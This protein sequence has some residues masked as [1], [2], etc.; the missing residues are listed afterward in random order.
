MWTWERSRR[1]KSILGR[2]CILGYPDFA[3]TR[4]MAAKFDGGVILGAD[5]RTTMGI[6]GL[7]VAC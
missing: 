7:N 3:N 1:A 6:I 4:S 5:S 2:R